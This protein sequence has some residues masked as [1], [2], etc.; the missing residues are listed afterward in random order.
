MTHGRRHLNGSPPSVQLAGSLADQEGLIHCAC[1]KARIAAFPTS[2]TMQEHMAWSEG[3]EA[4]KEQQGTYIA[5]LEA[6][7]DLPY[8][9]IHSR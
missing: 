7:F 8:Q 2:L 4:L 1:C 6:T 5:Q 3:R 9:E